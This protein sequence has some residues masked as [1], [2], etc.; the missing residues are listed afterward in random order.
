MA[1]ETLREHR[2]ETPE[3]TARGGAAGDIHTPP[4]MDTAAHVQGQPT[5]LVLN[6]GEQEGRAE[7]VDPETGD[8]IPTKAEIPPFDQRKRPRERVCGASASGRA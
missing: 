8:A 6:M 3:S 7:A 2:Q 1:D 4:L 5:A